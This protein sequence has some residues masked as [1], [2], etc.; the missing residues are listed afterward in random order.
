MTR[1]LRI[2]FPGALYHV[3]SRG[4][5]REDLFTDDSDRAELLAVMAQ[6]L[7]RFD[8]VLPGYCLMSNHYHFVLNEKSGSRNRGHVS[9][10][11][12]L[13]LSRLIADC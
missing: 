12:S 4:D 2:E 6:G 8:A 1:P 9:N 11:K 3:T 7:S 13:P 10:L 5:R